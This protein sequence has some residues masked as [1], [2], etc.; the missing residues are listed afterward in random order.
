MMDS[1]VSPNGGFKDLS[2]LGDLSG[3]R[4][5]LNWETKKPSLLLSPLRA[6]SFFPLAF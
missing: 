3:G 4:W 2:L 1:F 5:R 6:C